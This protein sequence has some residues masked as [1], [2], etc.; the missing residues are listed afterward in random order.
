LLC[1]NP[2]YGRAWGH[3]DYAKDRCERN[4]LVGEYQLAYGAGWQFKSIQ[5][6]RKYWPKP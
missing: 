6:P 3:C 2:S 4:Y 5:L 1:R